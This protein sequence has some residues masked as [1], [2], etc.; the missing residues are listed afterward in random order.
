MEGA[1][2][3]CVPEIHIYM[4]CIKCVAGKMKQNQ[5]LEGHLIVVFKEILKGNR[6]IRIN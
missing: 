5:L 4:K 6:S 2:L 1:Y 3:S